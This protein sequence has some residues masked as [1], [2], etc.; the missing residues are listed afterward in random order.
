MASKLDS[1]NKKSGKG[2]PTVTSRGPKKFP[3]PSAKPNPMFNGK[4][5]TTNPVTKK[6]GTGLVKGTGSLFPDSKGGSGRRLSGKGG[7]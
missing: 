7:L 4:P 3:G 2:F 6:T 5:S 1:A